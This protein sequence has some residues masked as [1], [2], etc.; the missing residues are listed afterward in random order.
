MSGDEFE[1]FEAELQKLKPS[2]P[3]EAFISRLAIAASNQKIQRSRRTGLLTRPLNSL[4]RVF[5]ACRGRG[6]RYAGLLWWLVPGAAAVAIVTV[7]WFKSAAEPAPAARPTALP[8]A[9]SSLKA[10]NVE[11]DR[12]LLASFDAVAQ[13]PSGEPVRFRCRKWVDQV[14]FRDSKR[15]LVIEQRAPHLEVVPVGFDTE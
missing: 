14:V 6:P 1:A 10:D 13:L 5:W 7:L 9:S 3:P 15:G 4:Y 2:R 11:I 12:Q 8:L